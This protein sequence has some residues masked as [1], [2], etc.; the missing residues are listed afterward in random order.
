MASLARSVAAFVATYV[1]RERPRGHTAHC[2]WRSRRQRVRRYLMR[3]LWTIALAVVATVGFA[4]WALQHSDPPMPALAGTL[5]R[6]EL[7]H[8]GRTRSWVAYVPAKPEGHPALVIALHGSM[9]SGQQARA[10]SF[11]YDFD[12]LADREGFIAVYPQGYGGQWN[13]ARV[14]GPFAA[15]RENV[16]D[17]GFLSALVTRMVADHRIDTTRVYVVGISNGGSM[18]LRLA[19]QTPELARAYAVVSASLPTPENLI[20]TPGGRPVSIV[21]MNGTADPINPWDG[22]DVVLWPVLG[23]R[24]PVHS[25]AA[26]VGYFRGLAG[27]DGAPRVTSFPDRDP[28]DGSSAR[29]STWAEPG[30]RTV[31]LIAIDGGG[32]TAPH[33]ARYGMRLLGRSNRD[34]HAAYAIWGFFQ[35]A[36]P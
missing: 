15:K 11:G 13:D 36:P 2:R 24:G 4:F 28:G 1:Y 18:V 12:V 21:F 10:V 25:V 26:S 7:Q 32:H 17:V 27:L 9:G 34:I 29:Q 23:N 3:A 16:D 35:S 31:A 22:G 19:L 8:G 30:K 5:E 33:P 6:G 14:R 20:V